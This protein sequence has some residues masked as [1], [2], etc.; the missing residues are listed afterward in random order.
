MT[1][2]VP[3]NTTSALDSMLN[4]FDEIGKE[5]ESIQI[6]PFRIAVINNINNGDNRFFAVTKALGW[7]KRKLDPNLKSEFEAIPEE[8]KDFL[9]WIRPYNESRLTSWA[10]A[11]LTC[12]GAELFGQDRSKA[13]GWLKAELTERISAAQATICIAEYLQPT[14]DQPQQD[15]AERT[16]LAM[17]QLDQQEK[18]AAL[19]WLSGRISTKL[20]E[21]MADAIIAVWMQRYQSR[22][23]TPARSVAPP[24]SQIKELKPLDQAEVTRR[25]EAMCAEVPGTEMA[26]AIACVEAQMR[27][28]QKG[29]QAA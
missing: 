3:S 19:Q 25:A 13:L 28:E 23:P 9:V 26:D 2:S 18:S 29:Q 22:Q 8:L 15:W 27:A 21:D 4:Y 6:D 11:C 17:M 12:I 7:A 10:T 1:N 14:E 24:K 5:G 20:G 16:F